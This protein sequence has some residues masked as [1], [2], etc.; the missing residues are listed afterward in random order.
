LSNAKRTNGV[1]LRT[2]V[3]YYSKNTPQLFGELE[4]HNKLVF[5]KMQ[6][7]LGKDVVNGVASYEQLQYF[8]YSKYVAG[9][10]LKT[11]YQAWMTRDGKWWMEAFMGIG[12]KFRNYF[13][14][15]QPG[16][17]VYANPSGSFIFGNNGRNRPGGIVLPNFS[18]GLRLGYKLKVSPAG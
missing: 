13:L 4:L 12:L 9:V 15:G 17:T 18:F 1:I 10:N 16:G 7:W 3:R 8:T 2:A 14:V 5:Y 6:D 11:G